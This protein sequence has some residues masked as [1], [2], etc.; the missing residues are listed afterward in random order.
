MNLSEFE[1][2]IL[3]LSI[4]NRFESRRLEGK[5]LPGENLDE[6]LDIVSSIAVLDYDWGGEQINFDTTKRHEIINCVKKFAQH[7]AILEGTT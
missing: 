1:I 7:L 5:E 4:K 3:R 2:Q 6:L